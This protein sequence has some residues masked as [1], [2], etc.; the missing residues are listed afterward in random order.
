MGLCVCVGVGA[1]LFACFAHPCGANTLFLACDS[2]QTVCIEK[3]GKL[4]GT[5]LNVGC[6]PSKSLLNNSHM[7]HQALHDMK[8]RGIE[9]GDVS[10]NLDTMMAAKEKSVDQLTSGIEYLFKKNGA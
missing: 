9:V 5:C 2:A 6:I 7:Y 4:G 10:L 8:N 1:G 3:R